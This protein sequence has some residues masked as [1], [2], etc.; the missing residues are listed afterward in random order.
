MLAEIANELNGGPPAQTA[1]APAP[2]WQYAI[3]KDVMV[4]VR[5]DVSPWRMKQIRAA[6]DAIDS[7]LR[8]Q[9]NGNKRRTRK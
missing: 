2:W 7:L 1:L 3:Q 6:I 4:W 8:E 9:E 5:G